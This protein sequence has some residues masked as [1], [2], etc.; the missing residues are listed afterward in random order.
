MQSLI[1]CIHY[2]IENNYENFI[3]RFIE[4]YIQQL[5]TEFKF[6]N[7]KEENIFIKYTSLFSINPIERKIHLL[8]LLLKYLNITLVS[9]P[10]KLM[11]SSVKSSYFN[12]IY[13]LKFNYTDDLS[14]GQFKFITNKGKIIIYMEN[15]EKSKRFFHFLTRINYKNKSII[16]ELIINNFSLSSKIKLF[17]LINEIN[18]KF[19]FKSFSIEPP[20]STISLI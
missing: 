12:K 4:I 5:I 8:I 15:K 10:Y 2:L 9:V 16:D 6:I 7:E 1:E 14:S 11:K 20:F 3:E 13:C 18:Q 19:T 17:N